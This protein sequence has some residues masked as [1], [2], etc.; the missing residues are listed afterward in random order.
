M[1][2][3][4]AIKTPLVLAA[5]LLATNAHAA[6][7]E[8]QSYVMN[9]MEDDAFGEIIMD[10]AHETAVEKITRAGSRLG[11]A[12]YINLCVAYAKMRQESMAV[13]A[14]DLAVQKSRSQRR[15]GKKLDYAMAWTNRGVLHAVQGEDELARSAFRRALH[16]QP[17]HRPAL[18]NLQLV[19]A[20][21]N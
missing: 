2:Y 17:R 1:K 19:N 13:E 21:E 15:T 11:P 18:T 16:A 10:G 6:N 12:D 9:V 20:E 14:C 7:A 8:Q 4:K 3:T 5:C